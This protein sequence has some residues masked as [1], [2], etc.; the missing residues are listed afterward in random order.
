[1]NMLLVLICSLFLGV[2]GAYADENLS[3][4]GETIS[5]TPHVDEAFQQWAFFPVIASSTETG[6]QLGGLAVRFL[7]PES[8]ELRTSTIDF[9]AYGTTNQQYFAGITPNLYFFRDTYH[10]KLSTNGR[11]W[12]ANFYGIGNDTPEENEEEFESTAFQTRVSFERKFADIFYA[13]ILYTFKNSWIDPEDEGVLQEETILGSTGGLRSGVGGTLSLD[14]RD[15]TNDARDGTYI[16]ADALCFDESVGS[17]FDYTLYTLDMRHFLTLLKVTGLGVRAYAQLMRGDIPFQDL[18]SAN[19]YTVLRGIEKGRYRERDM[20]AF[21]AEWRYPIYKRFGGTLFL[22]TAQVAEDL[23]DID[24]D[25]WTSGAGVGFRYALNPSE[26]FNI[27]AD[28]SWVDSGF[29]LTIGV[30]EAF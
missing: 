17:D 4:A 25:G 26:K 9:V 6:L 20:V 15:N 19:G 23:T 3:T 16:K 22:E 8:P 29:G 21:Q 28:M 18:S 27:R 11:F 12:P 2:G 1:M 5:E 13:G 10:L 7:E 24:T 30:R 14:T